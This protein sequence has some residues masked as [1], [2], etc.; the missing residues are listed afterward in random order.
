MAKLAIAAGT[1]LSVNFRTT[2]PTVTTPHG[3]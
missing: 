2:S 1:V 3:K